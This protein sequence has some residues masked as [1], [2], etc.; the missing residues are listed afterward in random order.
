MVTRNIAMVED[1]YEK[2]SLD[3]PKGGRHG[4]WSSGPTPPPI[5]GGGILRRR[6]FFE[7]PVC[8]RKCGESAREGGLCVGSDIRER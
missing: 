4:G 3:N 2:R 8:R 7:V 5:G 6:Q 1:K